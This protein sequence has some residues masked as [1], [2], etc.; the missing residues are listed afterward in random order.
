M[1][2]G[3]G[4]N[5]LMPGRSRNRQAMAAE[6][7]NNAGNAQDAFANS[8][9]TPYSVD[10]Q[11]FSQSRPEGRGDTMD[12]TKAAYDPRGGMPMQPYGGADMSQMSG[13]WGAFL[14][15]RPRQNQGFLGPRTM[16]REFLP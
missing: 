11:L 15:R 6:F 12:P 10:G 13:L 8:T 16:T 7:M 1:L 9:V 5:P 4:T 2:F 3:F 14:G